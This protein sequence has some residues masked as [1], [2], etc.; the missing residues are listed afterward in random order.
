MLRSTLLIAAGLLSALPASA[1]ARDCAPLAKTA[2]VLEPPGLQYLLVGETHGT[3]EAPELFSD[4]VCA[5]GSRPLVVGVEW[6]AASQ[7]VLEAFLAERDAGAALDILRTAPALAR[8]DGRGS[9][10]MVDMLLGVWRLRQAGRSIELVAFDHEIAGGGTSD[11]RERAMAARL[12]AA[13]ARHGGALLIALTGTGHADRNGFRSYDPPFKSMVQHLSA[14]KTRTVAMLSVGGE[15]LACRHIRPSGEERCA[16][17]PLPVRSDM[18]ARG[19]GAGRAGFDAVASPG[20]LY[21]Q[22]VAGQGTEGSAARASVPHA[23]VTAIGTGAALAR[24]SPVFEAAVKRAMQAV[25]V[26]AGGATGARR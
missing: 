12:L 5:A 26:A 2:D 15:A 1:F 10:A 4:L 17:A 13:G 25:P 14:A 19:I 20:R 22:S 11:G 6:P 9:A 3:K 7:P 18:M 23:A 16:T 8:P 21:S 24:R